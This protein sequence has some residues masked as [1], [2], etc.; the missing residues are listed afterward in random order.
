MT[1]PA[2]VEAKLRMAGAVAGSRGGRIRQVFTTNTE[3]DDK[4]DQDWN[5]GKPFIPVQNFVTTKRNLF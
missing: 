1:N 2:T 5:P 3:R 4:D